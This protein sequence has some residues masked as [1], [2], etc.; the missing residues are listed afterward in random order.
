MIINMKKKNSNSNP[1]DKD[2]D[3]KD[4][5]TGKPLL[6]PAELKKYGKSKSILSKGNLK[7]A[8]KVLGK[9]ADEIGFGN[10]LKASKYSPEDKAIEMMREATKSIKSK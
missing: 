8:G 3:G 5:K 10:P 6:S 1:K 4:D 9:V 7:K 2:G